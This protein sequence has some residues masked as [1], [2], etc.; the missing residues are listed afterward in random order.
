MKKKSR[1]AALRRKH[2]FR[3]YNSIVI[4]RRGQKVKFRHPAYIFLVKGNNF[5][6]VTIT[7]SSSVKEH[8][9]LKLRRNPNPKDKRDAYYVAEVIDDTKDQ[10]RKRLSD[11]K[12]DPLDDLDIQ[13]L[14]KK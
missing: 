2:E 9:V 6:F 7:H 14:Y 5:L 3:Y 4:N 13:N 1:H 11:W 12:I 8:V 10:F